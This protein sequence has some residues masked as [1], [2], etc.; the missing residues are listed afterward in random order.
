M[1]EESCIVVRP[2]PALRIRRHDTEFGLIWT[3]KNQG[4][5]VAMFRK[6][7]QAIEFIDTELRALERA[8][9]LDERRKEMTA[10]MLARAA[11]QPQPMRPQEIP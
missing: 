8:A 3:V 11:Q 1:Q 4:I 9:R 6:G 5:T 10:A 2:T 7:K